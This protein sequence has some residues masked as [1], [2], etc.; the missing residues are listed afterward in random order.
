MA[1][2]I[3]NAQNLSAWQVPIA[4]NGSK[5]EL[6]QAT[7]GD[8]FQPGQPFPQLWTN[9]EDENLLRLESAD[10]GLHKYGS[11][12][13]AFIV[14]GYYSNDYTQYLPKITTTDYIE[15]LINDPLTG[16]DLI[17]PSGQ[18]QITLELLP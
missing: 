6:L 14:F 9:T 12:T 4:F 11:G 8:F 7:P 18:T 5:L 17:A 1:L 3:T 10:P 16:R 15:T 2:K 13:L